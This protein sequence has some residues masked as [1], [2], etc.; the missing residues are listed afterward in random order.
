M[1][2]GQEQERQNNTAQVGFAERFDFRVDCFSL[3]DVGILLSRV[4][5]R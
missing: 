5:T 1:R 4:S 3:K 2:H